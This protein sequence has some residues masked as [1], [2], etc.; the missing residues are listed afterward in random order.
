VLVWF[1][2]VVWCE[3]EV[4]VEWFLYV[5]LLLWVWGNLGI[6]WWVL[7]WWCY[8]DYFV[9]VLVIEV[10]FEGDVCVDFDFGFVVCLFFGMVNFFVEWYDLDV[11]VVFDVYGFVDLL[12]WLVFDGLRVDCC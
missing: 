10:V 5:M 6:E 3:V 7:E 12:V 2:Y 11:L 8:F 4:F 1:E 9:V